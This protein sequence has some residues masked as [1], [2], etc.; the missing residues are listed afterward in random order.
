MM[1]NLQRIQEND[2]HFERDLRASD[3][4][5]LVVANWLQRRGNAVLLPPIKV[6]PSI[7]ER[8]QYTD[9]GDLFILGAKSGRSLRTRIEVKHRL[10]IEFQSVEQ[11]P[12][13]SV[14]VDLEHCWKNADPKPHSYLICNKSLTGALQI[15]GSTAVQWKQ[16]WKKDRFKN[17]DRLFLEAAIG[18]CEYRSFEDL[19]K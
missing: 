15:K 6:T 13:P 8:W 10:D 19:G 4:A 9:Q 14:I 7:A 3:R 11:F 17:R 12:Y 18:L 16:V 5:V 2:P 1:Q